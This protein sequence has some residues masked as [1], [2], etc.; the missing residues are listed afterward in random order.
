MIFRDQFLTGLQSVVLVIA[1][2]YFGQTVLMPFAI[3]ILLTFLL[4]PVVMW[5]ERHRFP[6]G[7]A[8]VCVVTTIGLVVAAIG[9]IVTSQLYNLALSLD[10]YRG[11]IQSK[12]SVL[13]QSDGHVW[14]NVTN[15]LREFSDASA[16]EP[17]P[18]SRQATIGSFCRR[19]RKL[20][21]RHR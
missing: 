13:G 6:R 5:L 9:G 7:L 4:R 11:H 21:P 20:S 1:A 8:I 19:C 10:D 15:L 16:A 18:P 2:L 3:A 14:K 12:L 17:K